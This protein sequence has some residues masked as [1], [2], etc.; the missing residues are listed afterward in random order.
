ME[1]TGPNEELPPLPVWQSRAFWLT[2]IAA[3]T[4][5]GAVFNFNVLDVLGVIDADGAADKIMDVVA[6][7]SVLVALGQ[8][9]APNFRL[10]L[11]GK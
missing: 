11:T 2:L 4:S 8:R 9:A 6:G 10:S 5:L 1:P 7:V 3:S